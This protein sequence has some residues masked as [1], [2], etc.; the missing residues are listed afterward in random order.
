M[1]CVDRFLAAGMQVQGA[2]I[3]RGSDL[4]GDVT[5]DGV[6]SRYPS[7]LMIPQSE[8]ERLLEERLEEYGIK[9]ERRTELSGFVVRPE[10]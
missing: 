2:R 6:K 8:T 7:A 3:S 10:V 4:I 1:G 5:F 9:V